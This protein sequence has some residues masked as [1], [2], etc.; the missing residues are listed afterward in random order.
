MSSNDIQGIIT[1]SSKPSVL[2]PAPLDPV[3]DWIATPQGDHYGNYYDPVSKS[4]ANVTRSTPKTIYDPT[5]Q[6][7]YDVPAN[8]LAVN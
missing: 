1:E 7:I 5:T 3:A 6:H 2:T 8:Y 4:W